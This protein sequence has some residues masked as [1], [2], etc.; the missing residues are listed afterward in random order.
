MINAQWDL[1]C[2][3][4]SGIMRRWTRKG[5]RMVCIRSGTASGITG[6][7]NLASFG[8]I[9]VTAIIGCAPE[10]NLRKANVASAPG[11]APLAPWAEEYAIARSNSWDALVLRPKTANSYS[12]ADASAV[13][14]FPSN[15]RLGS[16]TVIRASGFEP[17]ALNDDWETRDWNRLAFRKA[18]SVKV[19]S[20]DAPS[21]QE[22]SK[23]RVCIATPLYAIAPSAQWK[24]E[25][26]G[27]C[28]EVDPESTM[29]GV[30]EF[31]DICRAASLQIRVYHDDVLYSAMNWTSP[32][33]SNQTELDLPD[34]SMAP[35]VAYARPASSVV[36][37]DTLAMAVPLHNCAGVANEE[38]SSQLRVISNAHDSG[39]ALFSN[40]DPGQWA[41]MPFSIGAY[42][43]LAPVSIPLAESPVR[44]GNIQVNGEEFSH[45]LISSKVSVVDNSGRPIASGMIDVSVDS[46]HFRQRLA[47]N[48]A[49][50]ASIDLPRDTLASVWLDGERI[51]VIQ[52]KAMSSVQRLATQTPYR[53][54]LSVRIAGSRRP[55]EAIFGLVSGG[56]HHQIRRPIVMDDEGGDRIAGRATSFL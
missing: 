32:S 52:S 27:G 45:A 38:H 10:T 9:T 48:D 34:H 20:H 55:E 8:L 23:V 7:S 18:M 50:E 19:R 31:V 43:E 54:E 39:I 15:E 35:T 22:S 26:C 42:D 21:S 53:N 56:A 47:L 16:V 2:R 12:F 6:V 33:D 51:G 24:S 5:T 37:F 30:L 36:G 29:E 1:A 46:V 41:M 4:H 49:G 3:V 14:R 25:A 40:L 44:Q 11:Q 28:Y 13:R 17:I